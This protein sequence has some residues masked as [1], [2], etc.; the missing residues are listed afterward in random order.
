MFQI[1]SSTGGGG[2]GM[3]STF[4]LRGFLA[5]F[6]PAETRGSMRERDGICLDARCVGK[7][8]ISES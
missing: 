2:T 1:R 4:P 3:T 8:I 6:F 5:D 7:S